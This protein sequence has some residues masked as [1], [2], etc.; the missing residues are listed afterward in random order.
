M[1]EPNSTL[2]IRDCRQ[3][4]NDTLA[5][6]KEQGYHEFKINE[7]FLFED[8]IPPSYIQRFPDIGAPAPGQKMYAY[9]V[10]L[11]HDTLP[12]LLSISVAYLSEADVT[13][14]IEENKSVYPLFPADRM[15]KIWNELILIFMTNGFIAT[16]D[17]AYEK[18][19]NVTTT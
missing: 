11:M 3:L 17:V 19:A 9:E 7:K 16:R 2:S 13:K 6:F 8:K 4:V 15:K 18:L 12:L 14:A 1:S 5:H 10:C